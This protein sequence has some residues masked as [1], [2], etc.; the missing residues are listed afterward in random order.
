LNNSCF[1]IIDLCKSLFLLHAN[2]EKVINSK[3]SHR[4]SELMVGGSNQEESE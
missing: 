3:L 4:I 2:F 1:L